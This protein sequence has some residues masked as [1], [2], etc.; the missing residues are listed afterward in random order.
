[1]TFNFF[2]FFLLFGVAILSSSGKS[3]KDIQNEIMAKYNNMNSEFRY[4]SGHFIV[5]DFKFLIDLTLN[6]D[7]VEFLRELRK[8][9]D[10]VFIFTL[11]NSFGS[12]LVFLCNHHYQAKSSKNFKDFISQISDAGSNLNCAYDILYRFKIYLMRALAQ[13]KGDKVVMLIEAKNFYDFQL[14]TLIIEVLNG[15]GDNTLFKKMAKMEQSFRFYHLCIDN[16]NLNVAFVRE[17]YSYKSALKSSKEAEIEIHSENLTFLAGILLHDRSTIFGLDLIS[18]Q[19]SEIVKQFVQR[20]AKQW[21]FFRGNFHSMKDE[22]SYSWK[23]DLITFLYL[24]ISVFEFNCDGSILEF[25]PL[26]EFINDYEDI[27][28]KENLVELARTL[29]EKIIAS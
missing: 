25:K 13:Y 6:L 2:L 5:K 17:F 20:Q 29:F 24:K 26:K 27:L 3:F 10:K 4:S 11:W 12:F 21:I 19:P 8:E 14:K 1:M 16:N 15:R 23:K 7:P 9:K 22:I 28:S 18:D